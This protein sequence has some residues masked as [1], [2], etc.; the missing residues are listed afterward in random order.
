MFST[1]NKLMKE[2]KKG[3]KVTDLLWY[4]EVKRWCHFCS[5]SFRA[6]IC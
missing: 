3:E 5:Y 2:K 6:L 4:P 1:K